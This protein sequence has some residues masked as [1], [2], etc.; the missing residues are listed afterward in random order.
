MVMESA[1][2]YQSSSLAMTLGVIYLR[3]KEGNLWQDSSTLL[4]GLSLPESFAS[5]NSI[6]HFGDTSPPLAGGIP[7]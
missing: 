1:N 2:Y 6:V 4:S 7:V 5:K 3:V